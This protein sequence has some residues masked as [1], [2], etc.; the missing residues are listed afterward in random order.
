MREIVIAEQGEWALTVE[1]TG[2]QIVQALK[3]L[4]EALGLSLPETSRLKPL[5][6]GSVVSGT[7]AEMERLRV[8]LLQHMISAA[9]KP[10]KE[11]D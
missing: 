8:I 4:R 11:D 7:R 5:L 2:G 6:P 9:V 3:I 10:S 1:A